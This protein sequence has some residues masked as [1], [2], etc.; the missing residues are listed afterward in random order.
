MTVAVNKPENWCAIC[1]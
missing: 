1:P